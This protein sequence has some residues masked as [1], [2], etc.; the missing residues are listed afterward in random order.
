MLQVNLL[1]SS[2]TT[3]R[4]PEVLG[5]LPPTK[6]C[7]GE[8]GKELPLGDFETFKE[9]KFGRRSHCKLCRA[10]EAKVWRQNHP[11]TEEQKEAARKRASDWGRANP[12]R[13]LAS[14]LAWH[15]DNPEKHKASVKKYHSKPE[16][17]AKLREKHV[18]WLLDPDNQLKA[19]L[20][21]K[22]WRENN[23][24]KVKALYKSWVE[25]NRD[26]VRGLNQKWNT[27]HPEHH[28]RRYDALKNSDFSFEQWLDILDQFGHCCVYCGR[29]DK[30]LT[31]D[32]VIPISKGGEHSKENVVPACRSCNSKKGNREASRYPRVL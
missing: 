11:S 9:G 2:L 19:K 26:R 29:G 23:P 27:E 32:H 18:S 25:S 21:T 10:K 14:S 1:P 4:T 12:E 8:C 13:A 7:F 6:K 15:R 30:K 16:V 28:R 5:V 3:P 24:E 22:R 17:R 31:M 20:A